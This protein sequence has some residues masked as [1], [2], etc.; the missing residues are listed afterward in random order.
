M[1]KLFL[2]IFLVGCAS[3]PPKPYAEVKLVWQIDKW[4]D[5]MLQPERTDWMGT[6]PRI[7]G[8]VGLEFDHNIGCAFVTGTAIKQGAPFKNAPELHW[9]NVECGMRW[10]GKR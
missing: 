5:W 4:S 3:G 9:A 1:K 10:G 7:H 2:L 8:E 6:N